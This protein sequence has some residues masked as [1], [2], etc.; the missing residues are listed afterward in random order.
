MKFSVFNIQDKQ[1]QPF[2][3]IEHSH[4][5]L[6]NNIHDII[7][8]HK[9]SL[10]GITS[11]DELI[12]KFIK[13]RS[14]HEYIK[15]LWNHSRVTKEVKGNKI[16]S[17]LGLRVPRISEV[18]LG[19]IPS[20]KYRFI[21]YYVMENLK[22]SGFQELSILISN[23]SISD[24]IREKIMFSIYSGLKSMRD[25]RIIFSDFHFENIF[26]NSEGEVIWIDTGVSV[27]SKFNNKKFVKKFN[28]SVKKYGSGNK[29]SHEEILMFNSLSIQSN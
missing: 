21:G 4:E 2:V 11:K 10:V 17:S 6:R 22:K 1:S 20:H 28:Q 25:D 13:A 5:H 18:G 19:V 8:D 15:L 7:I 26:S 29:L 24:S 23:N 14:W 12:V 9:A 27:Y 3:T 16:L